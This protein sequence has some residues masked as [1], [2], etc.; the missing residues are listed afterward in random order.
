MLL[1]SEYHFNNVEKQERG[2]ATVELAIILPILLIIVMMVIYAGIFTFSKSVV[3]L[4]AHSGGREGMLIWN[5]QSYTQEEKEAQIKLAIERVLVSLPEGDNADIYI[6]DD[7]HGIVNV[8]VTYYFQLNLPFLE[9]ITGYDAVPIRTEVV[10]RY[11]QPP[12]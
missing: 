10:Y 3:L 2:Q 9:E 5:K 4:A 7:G 8:I 12:G 1:N 6:S 11:N